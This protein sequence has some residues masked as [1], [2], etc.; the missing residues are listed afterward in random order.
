MKNI[1]LFL[2]LLVSNLIFSQKTPTFNVVLDAGHGGK[3][4]GKIGKGKIYEKDVVLN[5]VL[6]VGKILE[7][8]SDI[9]VIYTRKKDVFVDLYERGAIA[10][11]AKADLF[12]SIHCNAHH[13]QAAGSETFVLGLS[14]N[15]RNMEV[16]KTENAVIYLEDN[17]KTK[18]AAYNI[19]SPESFIGLSIM[20]EEF[21]EQSIQ[22]AKYVQDNFTNVMQRNNR[23]VKQAPFI[24]LHQTYM[25]SILVE[26]GFLSNNDELKFLASKKGQ[27][28]FAENIADAI[29]SYKTW[30]QSRSS[31][32]VPENFIEET[33]AK[34]S[35]KEASS[36]K[37]T[38]NI[39][40]T[41]KTTSKS[42]NTTKKNNS[43]TQKK[44]NIKK[45]KV[46]YKI[47]LSS[48]AKK[49]EAKP[50]N[51]KKLSPISSVKCGN[52]YCY[53]YGAAS[54]RSEANV[55]LANAKKV[56]YKDAYIIAYLD[57]KPVQLSVAEKNE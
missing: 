32:I 40:K 36:P 51:F 45:S 47:Q 54:K 52:L 49:I 30:V 24:V 50:Y 26:T 16:A 55:L 4:P 43:T 2:A 19:N 11:R 10:N 28:D 6:E 48:S 31:H 1:L 18:Y 17:Y 15:D 22:L 12:V 14:A 25:P 8:H 39:K 41:A 56:G 35:E 44:G 23:G 53:L 27:T 29:L 38:N 57:G 20:Q 5:I 13:T 42:S 33:P 34:S 21:L 3:D 37:K 7:Q 46:V 9:Q